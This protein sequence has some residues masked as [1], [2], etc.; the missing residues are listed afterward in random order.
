PEPGERCPR[1]LPS[2]PN[3]RRQGPYSCPK[4]WAHRLRH[5]L[6]FPSDNDPDCPNDEEACDEH[7][8]VRTASLH[9][10][11]RNLDCPLLHMFLTMS[12]TSLLTQ[13]MHPLALICVRC[14]AVIPS[15]I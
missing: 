7:Q 11:S 2:D 13:A 5:E 10:A 3:S 15:A 1:L 14:N 12:S 8:Q 4:P 9:R 6:H